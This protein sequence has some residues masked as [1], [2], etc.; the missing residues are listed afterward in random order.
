MQS[1]LPIFEDFFALR[2]V[3]DLYFNNDFSEFESKEYFDEITNCLD[4]GVQ[5]QKIYHRD[6]KTI[7]LDTTPLIPVLIPIVGQYARFMNLT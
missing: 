4:L 2:N 6:V 7:L 3:V 5:K 1:S